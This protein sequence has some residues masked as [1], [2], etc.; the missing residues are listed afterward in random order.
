MTCAL[1]LTVES[2][3]ELWYAQKYENEHSG[4]VTV[5]V[6]PP[7]STDS[8]AGKHVPMFGAVNTKNSLVLLACQL[9]RF[10]TVEISC[11]SCWSVTQPADEEG[12]LAPPLVAATGV[13]GQLTG[14]SDGRGSVSVVVPPNVVRFWMYCGAA[15]PCCWVYCVRLT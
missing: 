3:Y 15:P 7:W 8:V 4:A 12:A 2:K 9:W 1:G 11:C 13:S 14:S 6:T 5:V 10:I